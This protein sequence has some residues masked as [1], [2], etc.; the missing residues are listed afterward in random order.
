MTK[1]DKPAPIIVRKTPRGLSPVM[2]GDAEDLMNFP[3]NTEFDLVPRTKRSWPQLKLYWSVLGRVVKATQGWPSAEH[4][5]D[6]IKLT[7]GY[8]RQLANLRTGEVTETVDSIALDKMKPEQ[9]REFFDDAMRLLAD[10]LE[11]DPLAFMEAAA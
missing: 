7:L 3:L 4:L 9:F 11:Y 8:R 2:A 10:R 5:S 6:E 1:R